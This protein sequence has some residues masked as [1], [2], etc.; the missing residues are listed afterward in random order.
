MPPLTEA[1]TAA[2]FGVIPQHPLLSRRDFV[3]AGS[4][5]VSDVTCLPAF[6]GQPAWNF[7]H[8]LHDAEG[9]PALVSLGFR[10]EW[11]VFAGVQ[12]L[13]SDLGDD[14]MEVLDTIREPLTSAIA[15]R[16]ELDRSVRRLQS[17]QVVDDP[18]KADAG[19]E[20]D[21]APAPG[22]PAGAGRFASVYRPLDDQRRAVTAAPLTNREAEVL[23]LVAA[24]WTNHKVGRALAITERT[25]R[26]HLGNVYEKLG[27]SGRTSATAWWATQP[28]NQAM[29]RRRPS[30]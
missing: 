22:N 27:V 4:I 5:R 21:A 10:S 24:G 9:Y 6:W 17:L 25:V 30:K 7:I 18:L 23:A 13:H 16:S 1:S 28:G 2:S 8:G 3:G 26:K 29:V 19:L 15:F 14:D 20:E 11:A 12:R